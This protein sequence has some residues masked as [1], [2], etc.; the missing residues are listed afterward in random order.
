MEFAETAAAVLGTDDMVAL[1][2]ARAFAL[3]VDPEHAGARYDGITGGAQASPNT[4]IRYSRHYR[5][6]PQGWRGKKAL[7]VEDTGICVIDAEGRPASAQGVLRVIDDR[8]EREE[9]TAF[10]SHHDEL[11]RQLNRT[12]LSQ[13]LTRFLSS[14]GRIPEKGALLLASIDDLTLVNETYGF[15]IGDKVIAIVSRRLSRA[16]RGKDRIG[17]FSLNKFGI[18][19]HECDA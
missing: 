15:D 12:R 4:E 6:L 3:M 2:K 1:G 18:I 11:T 14:A 17:R 7:W 13:E 5:F 10:A 9:R 16:L 19:L 8:R